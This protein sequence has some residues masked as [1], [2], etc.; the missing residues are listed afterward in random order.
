MPKGFLLKRLE[1][2]SVLETVPYRPWCEGDQQE[3][4]VDFSIKNKKKIVSSGE[5]TDVRSQLFVRTPDSGFNSPSESEFLRK[6]SSLFSPVNNICN[7][8]QKSSHLQ[9]EEQIAPLALIKKKSSSS[10]EDER[11]SPKATSSLQESILNLHS[12]IKNPN[13][14]LTSQA[15]AFQLLSSYWSN[16]PSSF[17]NS[18]PL[19]SLAYDLSLS[20]SN[21]RNPSNTSAEQNVNLSLSFAHTTPNKSPPPSPDVTVVSPIKRK[22]PSCTVT[23]EKKKSIKK[24]KTSRRLNFD[25]DKTSPVSGTIIRQLEEGEE[26]LVVRKGDIDPAYNVVE[27]TEEAKA[28][29]SKI[30][31]KIGDYVCRLCKELYDDA[32]GLAQH[33]CS[34]I[35]HVEYRC[36]ECDKV[37]NCPAN[38]ASHRRWHKP[39]GNASM[40]S[41]TSKGSKIDSFNEN[42]ASK[43]SSSDISQTDLY[44][45]NNNN[46]INK[47]KNIENSN[48]EPPDLIPLPEM[49]S[50]SSEDLAEQHECSI[51]FKKFKRQS[52]LRK[53]LITH[54]S[55]ATE[56]NE[57]QNSLHQFSPLRSPHE[58]HPFFSPSSPHLTA[59]LLS[60]PF[61]ENVFRCRSC[62]ATFFTP[63]ALQLHSSTLH[64][65][66][67]QSPLLMPMPSQ[68]ST[69]PGMLSPSSL[70][71]PYPFIHRST[72]ISAPS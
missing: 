7:L 30:E 40:N 34:R 27:I 18:V 63:A 1:S 36:P 6:Q 53:H 8:Y 4:P 37:F 69:N 52:Y 21:Y 31:N 35:I 26:P 38:L 49:A 24:T 65:S 48:S 54:N 10:E 66:D 56:E 51:C 17:N 32:F 16:A 71:Q 28:E 43:S 33:R 44:S 13:F 68:Y 2:M 42:E 64:G 47:N 20:H 61:P 14:I 11:L 39:K 46:N 12:P 3:S 57:E 58:K 50:Y 15:N 45:N 23:P 29:L 41:S 67:E 25:E 60:P 62:P 70:Y 55:E 9:G 22:T 19:R 59:P 5:T 72:Q